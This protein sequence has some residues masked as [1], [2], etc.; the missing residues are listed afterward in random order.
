[1]RI[2]AF[3]TCGSLLALAA[4]SAN[5]TDT[6]QLPDGTAT[7]GNDLRLSQANAD[8]LE[9]LDI[10]DAIAEP[11]TDKQASAADS[12]EARLEQVRT[13]RSQL[14]RLSA[15]PSF[16]GS[17]LPQNTVPSLPGNRDSLQQRIEALNRSI[18]SRST[19]PSL[20][21]VAAPRPAQPP[22]ARPAAA[23]PAASSPTYSVTPLPSS[24]PPPQVVASANSSAAFAEDAL[25]TTA[26]NQAKAEATPSASRPQS[27]AHQSTMAAG[28][29]PG[30]LI[31]LSLTPNSSRTGE[32]AVNH[33]QTT[34]TASDIATTATAASAAIANDPDTAEATTDQNLSAARATAPARA[35]RPLSSSHLGGIT[36]AGTPISLPQQPELTAA[37]PQ[38]S[39][40][41]AGSTPAT[42]PQTPAANRAET[43][44]QELVQEIQVARQTLT[45]EAAVEDLHARIR[46]ARLEAN[47]G[48]PARPAESLPLNPATA[49][50][51]NRPQPAN[52]PPTPLPVPL[53][54]TD[55]QSP[56]VA[57]A[58]DTD[59]DR[60][61]TTPPVQVDT[62]APKPLDLTP[63]EL[64]ADPDQD[65]WL[66]SKSCPLPE[67][68]TH[69]DTL[70]AEEA[71]AI[72]KL[73]CKLLEQRS[74][75]S[76]TNEGIGAENT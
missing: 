63:V 65:A 37:N 52:A 53:L 6:N 34:L 26:G 7:D 41:E 45:S 28:E 68:S 19:G 23:A 50:T 33:H 5:Q 47:L 69:P 22:A 36:A 12:L 27:G 55:S 15:S 14:P 46:A 42:S 18:A 51:A 31:H 74:D 11:E 76:R 32:V 40:Q 13:Q 16:S 67:E 4:C 38:F 56:R 64:E 2:W 61:A 60:S 54:E 43:P 75:L 71:A 44:E 25:P 73:Q 21:V 29:V 24:V 17:R 39:G 49:T 1:M 3:A 59:S 58:P 8:D 10:S 72:R 70:E 48:S 30:N 9:V 57:T 35:A 20:P 66:Q 62:A